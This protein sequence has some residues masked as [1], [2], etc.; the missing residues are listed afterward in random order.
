MIVFRVYFV[1][2]LY[3]LFRR[4][5]PALFALGE[6]FPSLPRDFTYTHNDTSATQ[7][8]S[9][10]CEPGTSASEVWL[11]ANETPLLHL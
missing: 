4:F 1:E 8:H 11:V 5:F 2:P 9:G 7:D 6:R 10:R 3:V